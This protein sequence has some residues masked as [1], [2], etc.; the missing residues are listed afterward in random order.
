MKIIWCY[1]LSNFPEKEGLILRRYLGNWLS[2]AE[3]PL[4]RQEKSVSWHER[5]RQ[6]ERRTAA[7]GR[8]LHKQHPGCGL[9]MAHWTPAS[10]C[11]CQC[12][13]ACARVCLY[14][15]VGKWKRGEWS[16]C[17]DR[18]KERINYN[19]HDN[20]PE[21]A[22]GVA[23]DLV[24]GGDWV[25]GSWCSSRDTSAGPSDQPETFPCCHCV[26]AFGLY[27]LRLSGPA[28][29]SSLYNMSAS[30]WPVPLV[31][32]SLGQGL[33]EFEQGQG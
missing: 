30:A 15:C 22:S 31:Y 3:L 7:W 1:N 20:H 25:G 11:V 16:H 6:A 32:P 13:C 23:W 4:G 28:N 21:D 8:E 29:T 12:A 26:I 18:D 2:E 27:L 33:W 10:V 14:A 17:C 24:V 9:R 19:G 5:G